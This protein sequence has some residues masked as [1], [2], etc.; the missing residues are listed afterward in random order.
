MAR[1]NHPKYR[2]RRTDRYRV[3]LGVCIPHRTA[4]KWVALQGQRK[5]A[6]TPGRDMR[7]LTVSSSSS[8]MSGAN[9]ERQRQW[10]Y[11]I[12][13]LSAVQPVRRDVIQFIQP[14][15]CIS[16]CTHTHT[17]MYNIS[18]CSSNN[19]P[20]CSPNIV[21]VMKSRR[22][23]WA[24]HVARMGRGEVYSEFW[25]GKLKKRDHLE[26]PGVNGRIILRWIFRKWD[27]G[28]WTVSS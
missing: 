4:S 14:I 19:D 28:V 7:V 9:V 5:S 27:V 23:S 15:T 16:K 6:R 26:D 18:T 2:E 12:K 22:K 25:W 24:G 13:C 8:T 11:D 21:R 10:N 1:H 3:C 20:N 17:Y